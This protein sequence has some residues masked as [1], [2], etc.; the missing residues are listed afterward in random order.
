[1]EDVLTNFE[2]LEVVDGVGVEAEWDEGHLL[3]V[4]NENCDVARLSSDEDLLKLDEVL[5]ALDVVLQVPC[6]GCQ[7]QW[8]MRVVGLKELTA[9]DHNVKED[10]EKETYEVV[11]ED[12]CD[13]HIKL[14]FSCVL[15]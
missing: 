13:L 5:Q 4:L 6:V 10:E 14:L 9:E 2:L 12:D 1:M 7:V 3:L 8:E 11:I 15:T